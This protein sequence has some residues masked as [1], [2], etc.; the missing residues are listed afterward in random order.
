MNV[1]TFAE[2]QPRRS[3]TIL[4]VYI[5]RQES[6]DLD[7]DY[8]VSVFGLGPKNKKEATLILLK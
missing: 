1:E 2:S 6:H 8:L 5:F 3:I 7:Q 4:R